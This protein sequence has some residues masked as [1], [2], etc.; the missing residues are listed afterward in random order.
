MLSFL[1]FLI[2][3]ENYVILPLIF[4]NGGELR[5]PL[6]LFLI[7]GVENYVPLPLILDNWCG[8]LCSPS[9]YF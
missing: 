4:D 1:L 9:S 2:M 7:I 5:F 6:L 3:G 8:E